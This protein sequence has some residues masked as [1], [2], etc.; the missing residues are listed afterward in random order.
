MF[1]KNSEMRLYSKFFALFVL[2]LASCVPYHTEAEAP[3]S[4]G[5]KEDARPV[6]VGSYLLYL[7]AKQDKD[8]SAAVRYLRQALKEDPDNSAL[9]TEMFALLSLEGRIDDAYPY[10]VKELQTSPDSLLASLVVVTYHASKDDFAA[11][12]KQIDAYPLK[13]ENAFLHPLLEVWIQAGMNDRKKALFSLEQINQKGLETLY[14][15][16]AALLYDLWDDEDQ[17]KEHYEAL[18]AEP[19]GLSLRAAQAYGNF[20]LR[21]GEKKKFDSLVQAYRKGAKSYPLLDELFFTAGA[22][23]PSKKVPKSVATPKAGLAEAFFDISGSLADKGNPEISLYFTRFSL[24][25]DPSLSLARVLL[26]EI[27][28]KQERYDEALKLYGEEKENSETYFASQVRMGIIFSKQGNLKGA[29]KKLRSL[30]EKRPELAFPWIELGDIFITNK[31]YEQAIDAYSEAINRVSVPNRSHWS[32]FYSRGAAYERNKQWDL[33]EQDL[34]Q[35]LVL[36]P[37]QP[38]TL[39]YLGYSWIERGKNISK[40]KE[41]LERAIFLSPREGFIADSLGWAYYL[42]KDYARAAAVLENAVTFDPGSGVINDHL[43]DAYWRI[44]R[45]REARYQWTKALSVKDDFSEGDRQRVEAKLEK[46]LDEVGDKIRQIP[47]SAEK[48]QKAKKSK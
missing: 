10:A 6:S 5:T 14:H 38:L 41:M 35:A 9:Q 45:K 26:G 31:K 23:L 43:G 27:Y 30:A 15:F 40:A 16:H 32:L 20:L 11:A 7:Q 21:Q 1:G 12:Q 8:F 24:V 3:V 25:L 39:N 47:V 13:E 19:G 46:G 17:A 2:I 29:E 28:E 42:L 18:L 4:K 34:L 37:D 36:S 33:A 48:K 22:S 44:G